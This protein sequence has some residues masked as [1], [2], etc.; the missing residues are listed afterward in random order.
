MKKEQSFVKGHLFTKALGQSS[1]AGVGQFA[2]G[3]SLTEHENSKR[4]N[5]WQVRH[6][7]KH[8]DSYASVLSRQKH[9]VKQW[10][11]GSLRRRIEF[12]RDGK[13]VRVFER[14]GKKGR[15]EFRYQSTI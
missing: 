7:G 5:T 1:W 4:V 2:G 14:T 8:W 6:S 15:L 3:A 13:T 12:S 9:E 11:N 10:I